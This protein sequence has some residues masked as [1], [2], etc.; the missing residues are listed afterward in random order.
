MR[1]LWSLPADITMIREPHPEFDRGGFSEKLSQ[2][3]HVLKRAYLHWDLHLDYQPGSKAFG[4]ARFKNKVGMRSDRPL[5]NGVG[6]ASKAPK[7]FV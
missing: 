5:L 4:W 7:R 6:T 1:W 3:N 2:D